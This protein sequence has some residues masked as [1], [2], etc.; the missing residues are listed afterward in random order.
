[1]T[2]PTPSPLA[3]QQPP[4]LVLPDYRGANVCGVV[5]GVLGRTPGS[6][7]SWFPEP[8]QQARQVVLLV[9]DGLGWLQWEPRRH[10]TPALASMQGGPITT[11][12]PTTTATALTSIATGLSPAEHGVVGY[13]IDLGG[14][15][16]NTLRWATSKG[17]VRRV[18]VPS[19]VQPVPPFLGASV[20]VISKV[21][22]ES[23]AFSEAH[24]RGSRMAGWRTSSGLAVEVGRQLR[25]G[26]PFVYAYYDGIDKV[27]H[28]RG[29]GE[30][31][32][33]ELIAAD[34]LVGDVLDQL[35]PGA[36]LAVIADHGQVQVGDNV[37]TPGADV[38]S[39]VHHQSGEGRFRWL[40][41]RAGATAALLSAASE[42]HGQVAW[43]RSREQIL[44]E[45]WFGR[46]MSPPVAGR[47]GDVALVAHQPVSFDEP[48]DTGPFQL[49]CRHG[50]MTAEEV[51]VPLLAHQES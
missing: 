21:E 39:M 14:D 25:A 31:Y 51:L 24:L 40:H 49:I 17:D 4:T 19:D 50:S 35:V 23:S 32:D 46:P 26:E 44:D 10:L 1:V 3:V 8:L 42:A 41:A 47:L 29:F 43:V 5:P 20:P 45:G 38:L 27:A 16:V 11:V 30:F 9:V 7:P 33:A 18:H 37:L 13:R 15:V 36:A 22:L 48:A 6:R 34:R 2:S 12:A 28:E